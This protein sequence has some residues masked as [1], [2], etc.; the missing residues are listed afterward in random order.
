MSTSVYY[1]YIL[2]RYYRYITIVPINQSNY[3]FTRLAS[4]AS[5]MSDCRFRGPEFEPS[6][7]N[8]VGELPFSPSTDS[9]R[10]V[11]LSVTGGSM[12][13]VLVNRL[14]GLSLPRNSVSRLTD[15]LDM[16]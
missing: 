3:L 12:H 9:R 6:H 4:A 16:T 7:I 5:S 10:A 15:C 8:F 13:L 14:G 1:I 2:I 11:T